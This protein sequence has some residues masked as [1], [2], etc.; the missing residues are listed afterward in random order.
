M[1][2]E[3]IEAIPLRMPL[4]RPLKAATALV[5]QRCTVLTR[6]YTS[7]GIVGECFSNN[8]DQGQAEIVRLIHEELVPLLVGREA[9]HVEA[10][11]QAM[12]PITRS[13]VRDRRLAVRA[14][15]CVDAAI[16]DAVGKALNA[17]L[18]RLWGGQGDDVAAIAMGGYY[19]PEDDLIKVAKEMESLREQG[20]AGCKLKVGALT[21]EQD[22]ERVRAARDGAGP[23]FWLMA[24][25]NQGW[26]FDEALRFARLVR[27]YDIRWLEE[28]CHW[29][30]DRLDLARLRRTVDIPL[31]AGQSE[32]AKAGC[33]DLMAAGAIDIC[34]F[35][36]SW[37]GGPTEWRKVAALA[38]SYGI[39]VMSHLEPQVGAALAA[40]VPNGVCVELMQPDRDPLYH[41]LLEN[42]PPIRDGR[43]QLSE[44]PGWGLSLDEK[45]V[46]QLRSA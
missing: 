32:I 11:W 19:W 8:E 16:W 44:L 2:I 29:Q 42:R 34:N 23:G 33:R 3:R 25:P 7:D 31:C 28:P 18:H 24:D 1:K 40:G 41:T 21:P 36:P 39:G 38:E 15:A 13:I 46:E 10:C 37:G 20:L 45:L 4:A 43:M 5:T 6:V 35:D 12:Q 27:P 14:I 22:A 26:S 30:N 9:F 17:P